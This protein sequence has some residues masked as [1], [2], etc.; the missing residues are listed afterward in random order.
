MPTNKKQKKAKANKKDEFYTMLP[1]IEKELK[2]Y[3][4]HFKDKIILC[5]CDDPFESNFFKYFALNFNNFGLKKLI[6]TCYDGSLV[7][8]D[9]LSIFDVDEIEPQK[10]KQAYKVELTNVVDYNKDGQ[11]D[12]ADVENILK[13]R[14]SVISLLE[15]NGDFRSEECL[16]LLEEADIVVT[17]PPFSLARSEYVPLLLK[18]NKSFILLGNNNWITDKTL[19]PYIRDNKVWAGYTFNKTLEFIM[20]DD[21]ELK[22]NGYIDD[23]GKKHGFVPEITWFTNL[24][25]TKRAEKLLPYLTKQYKEGLY[26]HYDNFNGIDVNKVENIPIDYF[27]VMGVPNTFLDK[28]NPTEFKIIGMGCGNLAKEVGIQKNYRGRTD[29]AFT[30]NNGNHKCPYGRLLIQRVKGES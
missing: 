4:T 25:T 3:K 16:K 23:N 10:P 12:L 13:R 24:E 22:D 9:Q 28:Y 1:D 21:Y 30:D 26:P 7:S 11:I 5:N 27:G 29:L 8:G 17:N 19:F 15:G 2:H 18:H 20:P 14:K 6:C